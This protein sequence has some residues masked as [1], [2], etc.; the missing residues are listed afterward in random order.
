MRTNNKI[1]NRFISWIKDTSWNLEYK[2]LKAALMCEIVYV[3]NENN[4]FKI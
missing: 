1:K 4:G 3:E 2:N